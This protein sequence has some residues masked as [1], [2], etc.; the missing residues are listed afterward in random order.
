MN[1][2]LI[3]D[4]QVIRPIPASEIIRLESR[5]VYTIVFSKLKKE[6]VCTKN[7]GAIHLQLDPRVFIRVHHSHIININEVDRY[8]K[9]RGGYIIMTDGTPIPVSIRKKTSFLRIF[10]NVAF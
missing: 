1:S 8:E 9:G 4:K 6:H 7:L 3:A 2:I 10:M 5:G